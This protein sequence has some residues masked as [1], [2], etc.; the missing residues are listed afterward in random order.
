MSVFDKLFSENFREP[1]E[2]FFKIVSTIWVQIP[3]VEVG[4]IWEFYGYEMLSRKLLKLKRI[5]ESP[6]P[7][8]GLS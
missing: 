2:K 4:D 1:F 6:S 3:E 8:L 5:H 7:A